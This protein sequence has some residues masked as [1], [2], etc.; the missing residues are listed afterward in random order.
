MFPLSNFRRHDGRRSADA[1]P[2]G[3]EAATGPASAAAATFSPAVA[4]ASGSGGSRLRTLAAAISMTVPVAVT[5]VVA[6]AEP[7]A[8]LSVSASEYLFAS[9]R[10]L[11]ANDNE[12]ALSRSNSDRFEALG[13]CSVK[14]AVGEWADVVAAASAAP[15]NAGDSLERS[16]CNFNGLVLGD[17]DF[18][19]VRNVASRSAAL[20]CTEVAAGDGCDDWDGTL[21]VAEMLAVVL[22]LLVVAVLLKLLLPGKSSRVGVPGGVAWLR[23]GDVANSLRPNG[24]G[25]CADV[26]EGML[27]VA[28]TTLLSSSS[29]L[30]AGCDVAG[31]AIGGVDVVGSAVAAAAVRLVGVGG[32]L[33][34]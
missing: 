7:P 2:T 26:G 25:A 33:I 10:N 9:L 11:S 21:I 30:S 28:V 32:A 14:S 31:P 24:V 16:R 23:N 18:A 15:T 17:D 20:A 29:L 22:L 19:V 5:S 4:S 34:V 27:K 13:R 12:L 1:P 6:V 8:D 3:G